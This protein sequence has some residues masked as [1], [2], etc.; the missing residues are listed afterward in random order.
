MV[1]A[2]SATRPQDPVEGVGEAIPLIVPAA[3]WEILVLQAEIENCAPGEVLDRA[4]CEYLDHNGGE[5]VKVLKGMLER[6]RR[7]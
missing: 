3:M 6:R 2:V 4:L 7:Q 1:R 5:R